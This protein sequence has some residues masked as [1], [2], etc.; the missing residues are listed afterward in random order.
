M[1]IIK[2]SKSGSAIL[3]FTDSG[4]VYTC[5]AKA[6][7]NVLSKRVRAPFTVLTRLPFNVDA[8]R[9]PQSNIF[10]E[11]K[12]YTPEEWVLFSSKLPKDLNIS[13]DYIAFKKDKEQSKTPISDLDNW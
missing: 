11:G 6:L 12:I 8:F 13:Y 1:A 9:F 10:Y 3:F 2:S 4:E 5:A 7:Q